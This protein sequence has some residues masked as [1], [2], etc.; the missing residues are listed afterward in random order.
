[1]TMQEFLDNVKHANWAGEAAANHMLR[2]TRMH[3]KH[4]EQSDWADWAVADAVRA[5]HHANL[6]IDR[7]I[8]N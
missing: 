7:I 3:P 5:A 8:L 4:P 1:M 2:V 6:V